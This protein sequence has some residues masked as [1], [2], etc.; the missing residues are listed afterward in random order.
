[1]CPRCPKIKAYMEEQN[2]EKEW[3]DCVTPDGL[4]K[5]RELKVGNVPTVIFFDESGKEVSRATN[6]EEVKRIVENKTLGEV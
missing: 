6:I 4:E 3:V 5:A 2:I 1:M